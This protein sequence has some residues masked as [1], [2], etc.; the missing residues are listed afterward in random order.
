M[1]NTEMMKK[2]SIYRLEK[3]NALSSVVDD[4]NKK[5]WLYYTESATGALYYINDEMKKF[6]KEIEERYK[7]MVYHIIHSKTEFGDLLSM[8][9]TTVY[10]EEWETERENLEEGYVFAYVKNTTDDWCS[11]FGDIVVNERFGGLCRIG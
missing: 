6:V 5:G 10:D 8:L 3:L 1:A 4:F 2:E 7:G 11:E 9:W